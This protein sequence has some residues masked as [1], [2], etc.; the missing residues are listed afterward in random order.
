MDQ[1]TKRDLI[2]KI[3]ADVNLTE[4]EK[5]IKIQQI[6]S[7]NFIDSIQTKFQT[8]SNLN[9]NCSHYIKSCSQFKF[10]CCGL[11]D[12]CKRCHM[13]RGIC[14][15]ANIHI[16]QIKCNA[17]GLEQAP[18]SVCSNS[19][20]AISFANSHCE[21]C[22]IWT[23]KQIYHCVDCGICRIGTKE[24]LFHC[25]DCLM[26]FNI[27]HTNN[28]THECVKKKSLNK[29][30]NLDERLCVVCA[31]STFNSQSPQIELPCSHYIHQSCFTQCMEQS[32]YKC[33]HCKKSMCDLT[34]HWN[35]IRTQIKLNPIPNEMIPITKD[36]IVDTPFGKFKIIDINTLYDTKLFSGIFINWFR[37][38]SPNNV[39][40]TL[41]Y[42][43]IK[44]NLY[45]NIHCNDCEKNSLSPFH[46]YGLECKECGSFNTQE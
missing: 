37:G 22:Q 4:Q 25:A 33:A 39:F 7:S 42:S 43:M 40:A 20:C 31:E 15:L 14:E 24:T 26:C 23:P 36:D 13:E 46:F 38:N 10:D 41:N 11:I 29:I 6:F 45:K 2:K 27:D 12:P 44:K 30:I 16:S 21:I 34:T 3:K 35:F 9:L 1:N 28:L 32:N 5:S 19:D 17:C 8:Q 18:S